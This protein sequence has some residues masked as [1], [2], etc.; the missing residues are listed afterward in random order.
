MHVSAPAAAPVS[1]GPVPPVPGALTT[2]STILFIVW[3]EPGHVTG[4]LALARRLQARG[5]RVVFGG[6]PEYRPFI[7]RH[8]FDFSDLAKPPGDPPGPSVFACPREGPALAEAVRRL[9]AAFGDVCARHAPSAVLIDSLYSAFALLPASRGLPWATYETDLP[10]ELDLGCPA[11]LGDRPLRNTP[12][13]RA[14]G[15]RAQGEREQRRAWAEVLWATYRRRRDARRATSAGQFSLQ[16]DFPDRLCSALRESV[17]GYT[18]G[19]DRRSAFTPVAR[20]PRLVFASKSL[21][22]MRT[23]GHGV[24]YGGPCIDTE[25]PEPCFDWSRLPQDRDVVYCSLGTQ[26]FR[27]ERAPELLRNIVAAVTRCPELFLVVACPAKYAEHLSGDP[28]RVLFVKHAPQLAL[29]QRSRFAITHA[30][31]NGVKECAL[32]GV[33]QL[34]LP[35]SHDQPRNAALVEQL[36]IGIALCP[37]GLSEQRLLRAITHIRTDTALLRRCQALRT[38]L[39]AENAAPDALEFVDRLTLCGRAAPAS[40]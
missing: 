30:G 8:G 6:L 14:L 3:P 12:A 11:L 10:R 36:G 33:P 4:P 18:V 5:D 2:T 28:A 22:F 31:F 15:A 1:R 38:R 23:G 13:S 24:T 20:G 19:F 9:V 37:S 34:V 39:E 16:S 32:F 40:R 27:E 35:L 29:L 17:G 7:E 25:R 26:S 21:D